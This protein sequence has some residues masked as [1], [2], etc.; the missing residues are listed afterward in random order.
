M[1]F[2]YVFF[3]TSHSIPFLRLTVV[4]TFFLLSFLMLPCNTSLCNKKKCLQIFDNNSNQTIQIEAWGPDALRIRAVPTGYKIRDDLVSALLSSSS[5]QK[6]ICPCLVHELTSGSS[7]S[8]GNL[9]ADV[10]SDGKLRFT[11][12][13]D[14]LILLEE[15]FVRSFSPFLPNAQTLNNLSTAFLEFL[16]LNITFNEYI[17]ERM[18]GLGQHGGVWNKAT[19]TLDSRN[20]SFEFAPHNTEITI[21]IMH[22]SRGYS[23]LFNIPSFGRFCSS[24]WRCPS[25][26]KWE[27]DA[28]LQLDMWISTTSA[29]QLDTYEKFS[30]QSMWSELLFKYTLATGRSPVY[31]EFS[32]GLWQSKNRYRN[33]SEVV[34]VVQGFLDRGLPPPSVIV[35]DF[36]SWVPNPIGDD[37]FNS[38]CWYAPQEMIQQLRSMGTE[39]MLSPYFNFIS[40]NSKY[41]NDASQQNLLSLDGRTGSPAAVGF[42][43]AYI[44]DVFQPTARSFL[45]KNAVNGYKTTATNGIQHWW[46]DCD[47]P[48]GDNTAISN[49]TYFY[50]NTTWPAA[51][52]GA[53]YPFMLNQAVFDGMSAIGSNVTLILGRSAW[54]GSQR[55]G[56]AVWS[57]D[58]T[59]DFRN[60]QNQFR[61]GLTMAMSGIGYWCTDI[62]GYAIRDGT[63]TTSPL[64]REL[65]VRWFQWGSFLPLFRV[66]GH[67]IPTE[68]TDKT[69]GRSGGPNEPWSFGVDVFQAIKKVINLRES[70]RTYIH[71]QYILLSTT[72]TPIIRPLF[73]DFP[74][75]HNVTTI[76]DQMMFGPNYLVAPQLFSANNRSVYLPLIGNNWRWRYIFSSN[77]NNVTSYLEQ[78][79]YQ[80]EI[81]YQGGQ[82]VVME[83]PLDEFPVFYRIKI[84]ELLL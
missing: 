10:T 16:S 31:P 22:S 29:T 11:R 54:A 23:I 74:S 61:A 67:R 45:M 70:L 48:C 75:D 42:G 12:M 43:S 5:K 20:H 38:D 49:L 64:F 59:S 46:L 8:N 17:G 56:A 72:G 28:C 80:P 39:M 73:F 69:C 76:D 79:Q 34:S 1:L 83:T 4:Y 25:V 82:T 13:S 41:F 52:I 65:L 78:T 51:A 68:M 24:N 50:K 14:S 60:L 9:K 63:N 27:S 3:K 6:G 47:E 84:D 19:T 81:D 15:K 71:S 40:Q 58:T 2:R 36:Y 37:I 66:H 21:P 7:L 30:A 32:T 33:Q 57:G 62:G 77:N 55:F 26:T 44:Y 53:A 35:I 18:Y